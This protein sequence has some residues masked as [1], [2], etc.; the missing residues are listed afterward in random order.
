MIPVKPKRTTGK[1]PYPPERK[2][3]V[4]AARVTPS[5]MAFLRQIPD[6]NLGRALDR[7]I[8]ILSGMGFDPLNVENQTEGL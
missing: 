5:T 8:G 4:L 6:K 7:L 1:K 3:V 2:R